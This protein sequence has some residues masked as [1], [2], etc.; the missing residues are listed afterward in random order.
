FLATSKQS[1]YSYNR[2]LAVD[3]A[4]IRSDIFGSNTLVIGGVLA[5]TMNPGVRTDN[6]AYRI[7]ADFPNDFINH[8]IGYRVVEGHF[9]PQMGF[10][11][12]TGFRKYSYTFEIRPRPEGI[13]VQY[14]EFKPIE[15]DYYT[16][17]DGSTQSMDY[18][19]RL[20]G[21]RTNSGESFEWN[22]QRFAD[23]PTDS[24]TFFGNS[25]VPST[26]WWTRW[27]LQ[28][29]T[30]QNRSVSFFALYS[31]GGFYNG[32]RQRYMFQP[33]ARLGG[34]FSLGVDYTRNMVQLPT[35]GFITDEAGASLNY[36][37][38]PL[39]NSS[40]FGQW[41]NEDNQMNLNLRIHWIP[42]IGS[43]VY[44]VLNQAYTTAG[45]I[46]PTNTTIIAKIAYLFVL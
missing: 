45:R 31:W 5:G 2:L 40:L 22:I 11:D 46:I 12:R 29:Q 24:I 7:Y 6:L 15:L 13:G 37:F 35:G 4:M 25:I 42:R 44:L 33:L 1:S 9:D 23:S 34:N 41:N 43:D 26:Y 3:G 32:N 39:L 8:F 20:L 18:E 30:N 27:E 38:S 28:V 21:F 16:N 36:G 17:M 14:L 19:G 10:A